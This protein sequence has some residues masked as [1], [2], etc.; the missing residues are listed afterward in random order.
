MQEVLHASP[1]PIVPHPSTIL[2]YQYRIK[3]KY[4]NELLMLCP[5]RV[6]LKSGYYI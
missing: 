4:R 1:G 3:W 5:L 6:Y 2:V